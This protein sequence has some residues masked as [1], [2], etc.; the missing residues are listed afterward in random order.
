MGSKRFYR[1]FEIRPL[2]TDANVGAGYGIAYCLSDA[3]IWSH[4]TCLQ[5]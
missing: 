5:I 4:H 2:C 1:G 3:V